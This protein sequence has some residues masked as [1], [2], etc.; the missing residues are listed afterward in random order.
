MF[1]LVQIVELV[2][3]VGA[4]ILF[5]ANVRTWEASVRLPLA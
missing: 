4:F 1:E 2:G 5:R 3:A